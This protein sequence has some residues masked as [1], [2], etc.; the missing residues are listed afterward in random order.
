MKKDHILHRKRFDSTIPE[1][2][3]MIEE[4][5]ASSDLEAN[6]LVCR[7]FTEEYKGDITIK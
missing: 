7:D 5:N 1:V 4:F 2:C 3:I 6:L